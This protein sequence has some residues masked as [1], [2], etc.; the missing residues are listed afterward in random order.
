MLLSEIGDAKNSSKLGFVTL[1]WGYDSML[2]RN[3]FVNTTKSKK[4][5]WVLNDHLLRQR[6]AVFNDDDVLAECE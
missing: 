5:H 3:I 2:T 4:N 6:M 1:T